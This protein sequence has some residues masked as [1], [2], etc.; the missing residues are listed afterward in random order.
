[1]RYLKSIVPLFLVIFLVACSFN[2]D[3]E[4][5]INDKTYN[6]KTKVE[7]FV[8]EANKAKIDNNEMIS[9]EST[10]EEESIINKM[11]LEEQ[12]KLQYD[13]SIAIEYKGKKLIITGNKEFKDIEKFKEYYNGI[14]I[15]EEILDFKF[16]SLK[17]TEKENKEWYFSDEKI[18]SDGELNRIF[19]RVINHENINL[20]KVK[21][22]NLKGTISMSIFRKNN[23]LNAE[24]IKRYNK[25]VKRENKNAKYYI[26]E[27]DCE[28]FKGIYF[29]EKR[30]N[31]YKA[32]IDL[33]YYNDEQWSIEKALNLQSA[34]EEL[35]NNLEF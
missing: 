32:Y 25:M 10:E 20:I 15:P 12:A 6:G 17:I 9:K 4:N 2:E 27:D 13:E 23:K 16:D 22:S 8:G 7:N 1:M 29:E 30:E 14:I 3:K 18:L 33:E 28:A 24:L 11:V 35:F 26:F 34:I 31:G 5:F 19:K 21:Y